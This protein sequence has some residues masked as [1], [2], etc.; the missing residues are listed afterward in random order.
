MSNFCGIGLTN[1]RATNVV[2]VSKVKEQCKKQRKRPSNSL[3]Q[4]FFKKNSRPLSSSCPIFYSFVVCLQWFETW[5]MHQ[6]KLYQ[7]SLYSRYK[8]TMI[9]NFKLEIL[10]CL[11]S[12]VTKHWTPLH[13]TSYIFA[14]VWTLC[15][16]HRC[17]CVFDGTYYKITSTNYIS[18]T[19]LYTTFRM[20]SSGPWP[21]KI[22]MFALLVTREI[23]T[24]SWPW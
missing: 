15:L 19:S 16:M 20:Y 11:N 10:I 8:E 24:Y 3:F 1:W 21:L 22:L 12:P 17:V 6:L 13:Q 4:F 2:W 5:C 9:K 14:I 7:P 23:A 18:K